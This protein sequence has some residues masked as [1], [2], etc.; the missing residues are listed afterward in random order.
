VP[1]RIGRFNSQARAARADFRS[2]PSVT[3]RFPRPSVA[4]D[5]HGR[6]R[7]EAPESGRSLTPK[8]VLRAISAFRNRRPIPKAS[9]SIHTLR[10]SPASFGSLALAFEEPASIALNGDEDLGRRL[11][12]VKRMRIEGQSV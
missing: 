12:S 10:S 2:R 6:N 3:G 9:K 1:H 11:Q 7:D 4:S 8:I 5:Q